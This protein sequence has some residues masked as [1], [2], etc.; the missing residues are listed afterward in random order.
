MAL[1]L[2]EKL[3]ARKASRKLAGRAL[4]ACPDV[5]CDAV[6]EAFNLPKASVRTLSKGGRTG[7]RVQSNYSAQEIKELALN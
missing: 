5:S 2:A 7:K 3:V 6:A 4:E 1:S